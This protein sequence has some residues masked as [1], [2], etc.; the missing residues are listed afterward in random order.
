MAESTQ[1][2]RNR[3]KILEDLYVY[4]PASRIDIA[5]RTHI[6]PA[7]VTTLTAAMLDAGEIAEDGEAAVKIGRPK[8]LLRLTAADEYYVGCELRAEAYTF[9]L[10]DATGKV[11]DHQA[12]YFSRQFDP[13]ESTVQTLTSALQAFLAR[14]HDKHILAVGIAIPGHYESDTQRIASDHPHWSQFDFTSLNEAIDLPVYYENNVQA[15]AI[16]ERLFNSH[17]NDETF[18][19]FHVALGVVCS[20]IYHGRIYGKHNPLVGEVAHMVVNTEGELCSCG[21]RGCLQTYSSENWIMRKARV[22][23]Q[24]A[25]QTYLRQLA[26]TPAALT[27]DEVLQAYDLGDTGVMNI[28]TN[29][30]KYLAVAVTNFTLLIDAQR[31]ILHGRIFERPA[32]FRQL[33]QYLQTNQVTFAT[34]TTRRLVVKPALLYDGAVGG[35]GLAIGRDRLGF[36]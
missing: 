33:Q 6:T 34:V 29:A 30:I 2:R 36:A 32:L 5:N 9:V 21:R 28:L 3:Q 17:Q 15:M 22:L 12:T 20:T 11:V 18:I 24:Q 27:F 25:D 26:K 31:I 1:R 7:T 10:T 19:F 14:H 8:V 16:T 13:D 35:A 4:A 23:Y